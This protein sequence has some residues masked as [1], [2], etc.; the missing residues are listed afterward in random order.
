MPLP[1]Q[2]KAVANEMETGTEDCRP[3]STARPASSRRSAQTCGPP[4]RRMTRPEKAGNW[5]S[6]RSASASPKFNI[7]RTTKHELGGGTKLALERERTHSLEIGLTPLSPDSV[8]FMFMLK[9]GQ[10]PPLSDETIRILLDLQLRNLS[11]R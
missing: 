11:I 4:W 5:T 10:A 2:L 3:T 9:Q 8:Q 1:V 7:V 6:G